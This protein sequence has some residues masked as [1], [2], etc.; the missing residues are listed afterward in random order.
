MKTTTATT[1]TTI[2]KIDREDLVNLLSTAL[3]GSSYLS[4]SYDEGGDDD[5]DAC[6]EDVM[7][8]ILFKG[9]CIYITDYYAEGETYRDWASLD[10]A[11][12]AIYPIFLSDI[13][14]GLESAANGRFKMMDDM[15]KEDVIKFARKSFDEFADEECVDFDAISAD[16]LMQIILFDEIVY[17]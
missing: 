5:E 1:A 17:G 13:I 6:E 8:D 15:W 12:N 9:G 11:E 7:A 3:Y 16:C 10:E 4:A 2:T 14:Q